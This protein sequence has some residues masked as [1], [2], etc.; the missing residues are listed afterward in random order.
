[1]RKFG[2]IA[3]SLLSHLLGPIWVSIKPTVLALGS[4][5]G[6]Q[7][8]ALAEKFVQE[9]MSDPQLRG[10]S[11]KARAAWVQD[12]VRQASVSTGSPMADSLINV[13][14]EIALQKYKSK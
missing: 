11:G 8:L 3:E 1:M 13:A 9:A 10:R 12:Q 14:I 5:A 6:Q 4:E 2:S 7:A